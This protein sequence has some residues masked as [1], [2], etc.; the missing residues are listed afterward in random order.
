MICGS[1]CD[2]KMITGGSKKRYKIMVYISNNEINISV[3]F[4]KLQSMI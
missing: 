4:L 2:I 3:Y 1:A